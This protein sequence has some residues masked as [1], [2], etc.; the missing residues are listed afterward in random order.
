MMTVFP[1]VLDLDV[2]LPPAPVRADGHR[3]H[4]D[5]AAP[6]PGVVGGGVVAAALPQVPDCL[7]PLSPASVV[8]NMVASMVT[9]MMMSL[10]S[11]PLPV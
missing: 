7:L 11:L 6:G 10:L 1:L 5:S 8:T 4:D 9:R 2:L 3:G